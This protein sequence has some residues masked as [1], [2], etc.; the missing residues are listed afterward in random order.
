MYM[1]KQD[2]KIKFHHTKYT[3]F[4]KTCI[5]DTI[6]EIEGTLSVLKESALCN[7]KLKVLF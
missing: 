7:I 2:Y 6:Y 4:L 5:T 3:V 1:G